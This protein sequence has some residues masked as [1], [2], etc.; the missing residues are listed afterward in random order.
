M[1]NASNPNSPVLDCQRTHRSV[2]DY[3]GESIDEA[4]LTTLIEAAQGASS[5]NF[6]QAYSL[7]RVNRPEARARIAKAAGGQRWV[8]QAAVFLVCC[9]D[10]RRIDHACRAH[11]RGQLDG[12]TEHSLAAVID[13]ALFGQNLLLAA[14]SLG[15]GGLFIG[16]I[17]NDPQVVVDELV[18][19]DLVLPVFGLCLGWPSE[20]ARQQA[21]K[22][23]MPVELIL[24]QDRYHDPEPDA[25]GAYDATMATYY[26]ERSSNARLDDWS[27]A[28]ANSVQ[29]KK[30]KHML[31][32]MHAR[33]FFKR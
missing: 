15:L 17:R 28:T 23:R 1:T 11:D 9:A 33:G 19:P 18:L 4:L 12:W 29:G 30:R 10:L 21:V 13:C 8:E 14:E 7:I 24:H 5:S 26:R 16:G 20:Q 32:F 27:A 3:T 25:I 22:P 6:I 31:E 2:R